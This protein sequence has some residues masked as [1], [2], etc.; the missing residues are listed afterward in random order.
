MLY[1][2]SFVWF[3]FFRRKT[4][5]WLIIASATSRFTYLDETEKEKEKVRLMMVLV[6]IDFAKIY[7]FMNDLL[8]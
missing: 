1:K 2:T 6:K 7:A 3:R 4:Y 5:P 8:W